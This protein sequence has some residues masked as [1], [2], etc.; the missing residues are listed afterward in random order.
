LKPVYLKYLA[1]TVGALSV[2]ISLFFGNEQTQFVKPFYN[3]LLYLFFITI[4]QKNSLK[5][6]LFLCFA[7]VA[8]FLTARDFNDFY[9][10]INVLFACYFLTGVWFMKPLLKTAKLKIHR[11]EAFLAIGFTAIILYIVYGLIYYSIHEFKAYV[12]A[13]IGGVSFVAFTG[14][15][16]YITLFHSHPKKVYLFIVG[17]CY[18]VVCMG[19]I[20]NELLVDSNLLIGFINSAEIIAQFFFV[21]FLTQ[22]EEMLSKKEW[23]I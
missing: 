21:L 13:V 7:T 20:I 4:T 22:K 8:E 14:S 10:M 3:L 19:Y 5:L 9:F 18:F 6:L 23:Y 1:F 17:M 11:K 15:C 16:F 12:P 2:L